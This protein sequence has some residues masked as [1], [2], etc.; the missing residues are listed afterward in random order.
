M[1]CFY[2]RKVSGERC[3]KCAGFEVLKIDEVA[4][5]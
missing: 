2:C 5:K 4:I 1:N 3:E